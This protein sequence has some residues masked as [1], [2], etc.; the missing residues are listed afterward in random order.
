MAPD[1]VWM[2]PSTMPSLSPSLPHTHTHTH[3]HAHAHTLSTPAHT[4]TSLF[5]TTYVP[6]AHS[7]CVHF[8]RARV[9]TQTLYTNYTCTPLH[10]RASML[11]W[12]N[13]SCRTGGLS[14]R[15]TQRSG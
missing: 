3:T 14:V 9:R 12:R 10:S 11:S 8:T 5:L 6:Y 13:V 1:I 7:M 2:K 4:K 15:R